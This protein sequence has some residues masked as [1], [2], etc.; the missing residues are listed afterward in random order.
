MKDFHDLK[1]LILV[2]GLGTRL[3]SVIKDIPKPMAPI[4]GYPFLLYKIRQLKNQGLKN[5]V[6]C[7]GYLHEYIVDY[8]GDG[9]KFDVTIEYS[10]EETSLGTAGALKNAEDVIGKD[11]FFVLN[12]DTYL[13]VDFKQIYRTKKEKKATHCMLLAIHHRKGHEGVVIVNDNLKILGFVE[14]PNKETLLKLES[15][16]I[17]GGIYLLEPSILD[18]IPLNKKVSLEREIFP[19][20]AGENFNFYGVPYPS[21]GYFI[22]IGVPENYRQFKEDIKNKKLQT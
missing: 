5:I 3:R 12:G 9:S 2:G 21:D 1:A 19:K 14:K 8:F 16:Y 11:P 18:N 6:F 7:A 13:N 22:D 4:E 17:N 20:M 15:P 10:I